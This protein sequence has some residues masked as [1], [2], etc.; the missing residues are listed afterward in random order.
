MDQSRWATGSN[1]V[2]PEPPQSSYTADPDISQFAQTRQPD[3]LF[4]D[5]F[6]PIAEPV[7]Q[8]IPPVAPRSSYPQSRGR[9]NG[10]GPR[11]RGGRG[12]G[13]TRGNDTRQPQQPTTSTP[14][15]TSPSQPAATAPAPAPG[16][17]A[18]APPPTESTEPAPPPSTSAS[19][20]ISS[21]NPNPPPVLGPRHLTGGLP[22]PKLTEDELSARLAAAKLNNAKREEA[23][24][25]AE[26]DEASFQQR[27]A[28]ARE[29]RREEGAARRAMEGERERNRLR[30]LGARGGRE[31]DEGK[32]E[33]DVVGGGGRGAR[34]GVYGGV[35]GGVG[36]VPGSRRA[37]DGAEGGEEDG[38]RDGGR[39]GFDRGRSRG[40]G[41]GRGGRGRG[42]GDF[43]GVDGSE[44]LRRSIQ[45]ANKSASFVETDFPALDGAK[46]TQTGPAEKISTFKN[47]DIMKS[48][49]GDKGTWADQV[50][51]GAA[52][53]PEAASGA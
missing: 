15:F 41:R 50:E 40:R 10:N 37:D 33:E 36:A 8:V 5:D 17:T 13:P 23:H 26:A 11:G 53:A 27:E 29:K 43:G 22:K 2:P 6:T 1:P 52:A 51:A 46:K 3:D 9:G 44:D 35:V 20:P 18:P 38:G 12:G 24:R 4:D 19:Q 32:K 39:G 48:P 45:E 28:Q 31:W 25:L 30:K 16:T 21:S 34:R 47:T 7:T 14:T 42:R 49:K